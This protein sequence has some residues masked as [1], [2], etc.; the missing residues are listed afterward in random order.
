MSSLDWGTF[1]RNVLGNRSGDMEDSFTLRGF[2]EEPSTEEE[3]QVNF[4]KL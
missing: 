2:D 4:L 3:D 1:F